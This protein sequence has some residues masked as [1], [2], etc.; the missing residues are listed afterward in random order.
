MSNN[1]VMQERPTWAE[2][3]DASSDM[4]YSSQSDHHD[5][6][7]SASDLEH[8]HSSSDQS[9]MYEA[10]P[11]K[12]NRVVLSSDPGGAGVTGGHGRA[13]AFGG[14]RE[15]YRLPQS[16][17]AVHRPEDAPPLFYDFKN[18][19]PMEHMTGAGDTKGVKLISTTQNER[20]MLEAKMK[21]RVLTPKEIRKVNSY[22]GYGQKGGKTKGGKTKNT[23]HSKSRTKTVKT[24]S[25]KAKKSSRANKKSSSKSK[26]KST[27]KKAGGK[28]KSG[29]KSKKKKGRK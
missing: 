3:S 14:P 20:E 23:S 28:K 26:K 9:D 15:G 19:R 16:T 21:G 11:I 6:D 4:S 25:K 13:P 7:E 27:Q 1:R 18:N 12:R 8:A 5:R 17:T 24:S 10:P 2:D 22:L 29:T